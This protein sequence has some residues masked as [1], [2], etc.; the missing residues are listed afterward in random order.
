LFIIHEQVL[1][2]IILRRDSE[3]KLL[4]GTVL[5]VLLSMATAP[6][7]MAES[8]TNEP[9]SQEQM[10]P[11]QMALQEARPAWEV[12]SI[13]DGKITVK[14]QEGEAMQTFMIMPETVTELSLQPGSLIKLNYDNV[15]VGTVSSATQTNIAVDFEGS[16]R[17][18]YPIGESANDYDLGDQVV[19]TPDRLLGQL[20]SWE[21]SKTDVT[22]V[23]PVANVPIPSTTTG[24]EVNTTPAPVTTETTPYD[25]STEVQEVQPVR[26]LW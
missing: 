1:D 3:M 17:V 20:S 24:A 5:T 14:M 23:T 11:N 21:L 16:N 8:M 19:A 7:V 22:V 2:A 12:Q 26:G 10:T 4:T 25:P 15:M 9:M 13:E 18:T 6:V